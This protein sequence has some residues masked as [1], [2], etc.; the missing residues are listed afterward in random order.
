MANGPALFYLDA[1]RKLQGAPQ[2]TSP[3][4]NGGSL[5]I[6]RVRSVAKTK[7]LPEYGSPDPDTD[8]AT[9]GARLTGR[10]VM[11]SDQTTITL[12]TCHE[13][14][15]TR[16][17]QDLWNEHPRTYPYGSENYPRITRKY[18]FFADDL[19][20]FVIGQ[21]PDSI[22]T[23]ATLIDLNVEDESAVV[24]VLTA[25]FD[26]VPT[27]GEQATLGNGGAGLGISV[28]YPY[29]A[30]AFPVVTWK[31]RIVNSAYVAA[32]DNMACPLPGYTNLVLTDQGRT[33]D[34]TTP[35]EAIETREFQRLP[36]LVISS[37]DASRLPRTLS[38]LPAYYLNGDKLI[39]TKQV[40]AYGTDTDALTGGVLSSKVDA[41]TSLMATKTNVSRADPTLPTVYLPQSV[42]QAGGA[43]GQ[44]YRLVVEVTDPA[45]INAA[46]DAAVALV[47]D[48]FNVLEYSTVSLS[49][50]QVELHYLVVPG[51]PT[52]VG[53]SFDS[54]IPEKFLTQFS[55]EEDTDWV[56]TT[57]ATAA[58]Y[59]VVNPR[60][61][62][63][64]I[65]P[66]KVERAKRVTTLLPLGATLPTLTSV[67]R[68][69]AGQYKTTVENV[70]DGT[71]PLPTLTEL[72]ED[73][74]SQVAIGGGNFL[75][76]VTTVS[77]LFSQP[78][79]T[80]EIPDPLPERFRAAAPT[81]S[82]ESIVAG[83]AS[84][85]ALAIGDLSASAEQLTEQTVRLRRTT[86]NP[87]SIPILKGDEAGR[88]VDQ[89]PG[90]FG[91]GDGGGEVYQETVVTTGG[92]FTSTIPGAYEL[93]R[94]PI[95]G[96][97]D[98]LRL[99]V[100]YSQGGV[101][102]YGT[103]ITNAD[104]TISSV[105]TS[106]DGG[107]VSPSFTTTSNQRPIGA[108]HFETE[109]RV[110]TESRPI[111]VGSQYDE[112]LGLFHGFTQQEL[113]IEEAQQVTDKPGTE[114]IPKT[115]FAS[116]VRIQT[117]DTT[118]YDNFMR[119]YH[120]TARINLP[121]VLVSIE[122]EVETSLGNGDQS[123]TGTGALTGN[124]TISLSMENS[125]Q[126]ST[127]LLPEIA[128]VI[129]Q[130]DADNVAVVEYFFFVPSNSSIGVILGKAGGAQPW[131]Q[132]KRQ[133]HTI[134]LKGQNAN[135][136]A[137]AN[138]RLS[139]SQTSGSASSSSAS[140]GSESIA[141]SSGSGEDQ[142]FSSTI[143]A[144]VLPATIHP[145]IALSGTTTQTSTVTA[146]AASDT[147]QSSASRTATLVAHMSVT[148]TTVPATPGLHAI[149]TSGIYA[150]KIDQ[151]VFR[152]GYDKVRVLTVDFSQIPS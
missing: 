19:P 29:G 124:G 12:Y 86:R 126:A 51:F 91:N 43:E 24:Q 138:A 103:E 135:V 144:V 22:Y 38:A 84:P 37:E 106:L 111:L 76:T 113:S 40:V 8:Y 31:F 89:Y 23:A 17:Q 148:P 137:Q 49:P 36:G 69:E 108:G 107:F 13:A 30:Q 4:N 77:S 114:I 149:P 129:E 52:L 104:G 121:P 74:T 105:Q 46:T 33:P 55:L 79:Y 59:L 25:T 96:T 130:A 54:N 34:D 83:V 150:Y 101:S 63:C 141:L 1:L 48:L 146:T 45:T 56:D 10:Q 134:I 5:K 109:T 28:A 93:S 73:E 94:E 102:N 72:V 42:E 53:A 139:L 21:T 60:V 7:A 80:I 44:E 27:V 47:K 57:S 9:T 147:G 152:D 98:L 78:G 82:T 133:S 127:S 6:E 95:S 66:E 118:Q 65:T 112:V 143:R 18:R 100:R 61:I 2:V 14:L 64:K 99:G 16:E 151:E 142:V 20:E 110:L 123:E 90:I 128:P 116:D 50:T 97:Q 81:V 11:G 68:T 71:Q 39:T 115:K 3:E 92:T 62:S 26:D 41:T 75:R 85:P 35:T 136:R 87:A 67:V 70:T 125:S 58:S 145:A 132:F 119:V 32:T 120:S 140:A 122:V 131:P 117:P 88:P 15:G